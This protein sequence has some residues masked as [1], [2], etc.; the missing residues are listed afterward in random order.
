MDQNEFRHLV[1]STSRWDFLLR[2]RNSETRRNNLGVIFMPK[3]DKASKKGA[4]PVTPMKMDHVKQGDT[5]KMEVK[6]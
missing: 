5:L 1:P 6:T 2:Y 3:R 4:R